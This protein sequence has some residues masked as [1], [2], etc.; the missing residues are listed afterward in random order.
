M[1]GDY[2]SNLETSTF[3]NINKTEEAAVYT[4]IL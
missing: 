2:G 3:W 4:D 1:N